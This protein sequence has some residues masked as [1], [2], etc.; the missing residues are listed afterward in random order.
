MTGLTN[1]G[2][3]L[4]ITNLEGKVIGFYSLE[5]SSKA[6]IKQI[7]LSDYRKGVYVVQVKNNSEV[8]TERLIVR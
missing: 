8:K 7:D 2:A 5:A 3:T 6:V 1:S 4:K